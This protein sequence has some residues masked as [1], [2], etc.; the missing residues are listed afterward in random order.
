MAGLLDVHQFANVEGLHKGAALNIASGMADYF[1][2]RVHDTLRVN[3]T[4]HW[5]K[6]LDTEFGGMGEVR[7]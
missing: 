7:S 1:G 5:Q 4:A 3:G 6:M 2:G